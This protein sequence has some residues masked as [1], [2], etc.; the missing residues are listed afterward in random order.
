MIETYTDPSC[1]CCEPA[2]PEPVAIPEPAPLPAFEPAAVAAPPAEI[3]PEPIAPAPAPSFTPVAEPAALPEPAA[4]PLTAGTLLGPSVVGGTTDLGGGFVGGAPDL[5]AGGFVGGAPDLSAGG[6][7]GGTPDLS[8]GG[9]VGGTTVPELGGTWIDDNGT[10]VPAPAIPVAP[11]PFND[12]AA[13]IVGANN[14]AI[15]GGLLAGSTPAPAYWTPGFDSDH[16]GILNERDPRPR[17]P[18]A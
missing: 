15:S 10:A 8:A 6:F 11:G 13:G 4:A 5:S 17:D 2:V 14:A 3:F 18:F 9:F 7:V 16:D 1:C 12:V